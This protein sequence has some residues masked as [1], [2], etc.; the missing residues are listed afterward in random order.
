MSMRLIFLWTVLLTAMVTSKKQSRRLQLKPEDKLVD[1]HATAYQA[2]HKPNVNL[3][4]RPNIVLLLTDDQ[5]T[6]LGSL[7]FMPKLSKLLREKGVTYDNGY[8]T[9]PMCC[10]SRSSLLTGTE[11]CLNIDNYNI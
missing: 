8:V 7:Q 9:T 6:Q 3:Q 2:Y 11:Q 5:D 4:S 10:P 1:G